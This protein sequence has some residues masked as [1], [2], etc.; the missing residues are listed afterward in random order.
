MICPQCQR[1]LT[2]DDFRISGTIG[3]CPVCARSLVKDK[4][5]VR[6]ATGEDIRALTADQVTDLR[7]ARPA[8][9]RNSV[10]AGRS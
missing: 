5:T 4:R 7:Q 9:W 1:T 8:A 3:V 10:R 2:K 6:L